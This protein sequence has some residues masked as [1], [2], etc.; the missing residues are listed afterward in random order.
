MRTEPHP[1]LCRCRQLDELVD[2][3]HRCLSPGRHLCG[4]DSQRSSHLLSLSADDPKRTEFEAPSCCISRGRRARTRALIPLRTR[5]S[6]GS[7][8]CCTRN[9]TR[10]TSA[11]ISASLAKA[12][13]KRALSLRPAG[14]DAPRGR[15]TANN[16]R[17]QNPQNPARDHSPELASRHM[18]S[19]RA[20]DLS[21]CH[22]FPRRD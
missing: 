9:E 2:K 14:S 20:R 8:G 13:A 18:L 5:I 1:R 19:S 7:R 21:S 4:T 15:K 3:R 11:S 12:R 16:R 22:S 6:G 10:C 17:L